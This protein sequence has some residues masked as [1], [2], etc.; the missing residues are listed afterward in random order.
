VVDIPV[1]DEDPLDSVFFLGVP[2]PECD[3]VEE[4]KPLSLAV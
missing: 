2:D 4:A 1:D 3:V